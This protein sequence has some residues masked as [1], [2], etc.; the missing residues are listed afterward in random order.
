MNKYTDQLLQID[1]NYIT[2]CS[3]VAHILSFPE[4]SMVFYQNHI[5]LRNT[6]KEWDEFFLLWVC[7]LATVDQETIDA[8]IEDIK[9]PN[10]LQAKSS[11][12]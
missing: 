2:Y 9:L 1:S 4:D 12:S 8:I 11:E 7:F 5:D 10:H 3:G 6:V